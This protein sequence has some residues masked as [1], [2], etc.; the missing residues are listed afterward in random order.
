MA[1][2]G[3]WVSGPEIMKKLDLVRIDR[4][5]KKLPKEVRDQIESDPGKGYRVVMQPFGSRDTTMQPE[6][7]SKEG[8]VQI[9]SQTG[10]G[11]HA[12]MQQYLPRDTS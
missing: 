12:L 1:A 4:T 10:K 11:Y 8:Q 7:L 5:I 9:D 2:N 3:G 6:K